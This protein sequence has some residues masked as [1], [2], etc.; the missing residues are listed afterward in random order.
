MHYQ[1]Q[2]VTRPENVEYSTSIVHMYIASVCGC[3][4][5]ER[6]AWMYAWVWVIWCDGCMVSARKL[7][8]SIS[9]G[10]AVNV[11][12]SENELYDWVGESSTCMYEYL[13]TY[14][15]D[16]MCNWIGLLHLVIVCLCVS[17]WPVC[18]LRI[19]CWLWRS[20]QRKLSSGDEFQAS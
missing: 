16:W 15:L 18:K 8:M 2:S 4:F 12:L 6:F 9:V 14:L 19:M 10:Y 11:F 7:C 20:W 17:W 5:Y 13:K 1:Y 3:K